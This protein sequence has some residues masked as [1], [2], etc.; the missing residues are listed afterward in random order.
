MPTPRRPSIDALPTPPL[1]D[2]D[3]Q[4]ALFLDIDGTLLDFAS[5]PDAV[6]VDAHLQRDLDALHGRLDGALALVSGRTVA[7]IDRLFAWA[8]R[9]AAGLHG[10]QL[11]RVDGHMPR[12][13]LHADLGTLRDLA[14]ERTATLPGVLLED[15]QS[16]LALHYRNAPAQCDAAEE[17]ARELQRH[18][19]ATHVLQY[20]DHSI[21]LKPAG[22]DKGSALATLL[23][24]SPFAGR[25]PWMFGDDLTDEHAFDETN[26]RGGISVIVG[27]RRPT[28]ARFAL[29]DPAAMR[30]WLHG[31][32]HR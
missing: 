29:R 3:T 24:A 30:D 9:A 16:A 6:T 31:I 20:G 8:G 1:P 19:A 25:Q 7:Q 21:E 22:C 17:L 26:A 13:A 18:V 11:R 32:A 5:H 14:I 10:A 12:D 27:A 28:R 15:K 4:W 23:D 2:A